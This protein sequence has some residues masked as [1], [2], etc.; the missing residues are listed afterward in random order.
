[1][2][3]WCALESA[4]DDD[5][6]VFLI[7]DDDDDVLFIEEDAP[8]AP[9]RDAWHVLVVDDD[10]AVHTV[11]ALAFQ[12]LVACDRRLVLHHLHSAAEAQQWLSTA[13]VDVS[14]AIVDV[15]MESEHAGL[16]LV[17]WMRRQEHLGKT[18]I[19]IRTGQPGTAPEDTI[20]RDLDINDYWSKT[21]INARRMRTLMVGLIRSFRDL[22]MLDEQRGTLRGIIAGLG[23]VE[24]CR[25][26]AE[27]LEALLVLIGEQLGAPDASLA[28]LNVP[29]G[30]AAHANVLMGTGRF[31][32]SSEMAASEVL[33]PALSALL[34]RAQEHGTMAHHDRS[35][36]LLHWVDGEHSHAFV[37]TDLPEMTDWKLDALSLLCG[38]ALALINTFFLSDEQVRITQ[39][40][41]RFVPSGLVQWLGSSSLTSLNFGARRMVKAWVMFCDLRGFTSLAESLDI[42][43][44]HDRLLTMFNLLVPLIR[45]HGGVIDKFTGDGLMAVF[46]SPE[47]PIACCLAMEAAVREEETLDGLMLSVGLHGG[48]MLLCTLGYRDRMDV[49]VVGDTVNVA[50]RLE[51]L[52][53]PFRCQILLSDVVVRS[54]PPMFADRIRSLG[55]HRPRGRSARVGVFQLLTAAEQVHA[56]PAAELEALHYALET[57]LPN[58]ALRFQQAVRA[59]PADAVLQSLAAATNVR[60]STR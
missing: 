34:K 38:N 23:G 53:R 9:I 45:D 16:D 1:M 21:E 32:A 12:N 59:Y 41:S 19:V 37:A 2:A 8:E 22:S 3:D 51:Q 44:T 36:A 6:V 13:S 54:V 15:V 55:R 17:S 35:V 10:A 49:T 14:V 60:S 58:A 24:S 47:P 29:I 48:S 25:T 26:L 56:M 31:V 42:G 20:L 43:V 4:Q 18:R 11:T 5:D 7:D 30:R 27:V 39:S 46:E 28:F 40:A 52:T 57:E 33:S 50:A